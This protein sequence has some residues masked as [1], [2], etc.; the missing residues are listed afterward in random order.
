MRAIDSSAALAWAEANGRTHY[1]S[2]A[3]LC[4]DYFR[5]LVARD[6]P[7]A[8]REASRL[9]EHQ[10]VAYVAIVG[11]WATEEP[12]AAIRWATALTDPAARKRVLPV[13]LDTLVEAGNLDRAIELA[14]ELD[15]PSL[16]DS[17][18]YSKFLPKW[19]ELDQAGVGTWIGASVKD[20]ESAKALLGNRWVKS[21]VYGISKDCKYPLFALSA[22]TAA[23]PWIATLGNSVYDNQLGPALAKAMRHVARVDS[24]AATVCLTRLAPQALSVPLILSYVDGWATMEPKKALTFAEKLPIQYRT[25]RTSTR[26]LRSISIH[27][28]FRGWR[29]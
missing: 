8:L 27:R 29:A 5:E 3:S 14:Y 7:A 21:F 10:E 4:R 18:Y 2:G 9:T 23:S 13:L 26:N 11:T 19:I 16:V 12:E 25:E 6:R 20:A 1:V 15:D 24:D 22:L 17:G 28:V